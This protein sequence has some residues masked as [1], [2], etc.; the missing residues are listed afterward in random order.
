MNEEHV[1]RAEQY[2]NGI[3]IR[4]QEMEKYQREI[5]DL[6]EKAKKSPDYEEYRE[7]IESYVTSE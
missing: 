2:L 6:A 4:Y 3:L 7:S 5:N 1:F